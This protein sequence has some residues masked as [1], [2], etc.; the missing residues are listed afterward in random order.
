M[1]GSGAHRGA[2]WGARAV[3]RRSGKPPSVGD[4]AYY[5]PWGNLAMFYTDAPYA[6]GLLP[7]GRIDSSIVALRASGTSK[8]TIERAP[9]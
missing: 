6:R 1:P 4:I 7:L 8:V 9:K 3:A 2:A 5:A